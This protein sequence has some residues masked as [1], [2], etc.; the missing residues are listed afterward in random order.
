MR[1]LLFAAALCAA[2]VKAGKFERQALGVEAVRNLNDR[3]IDIL[4][5]AQRYRSLVADQNGQE[6]HN[7]DS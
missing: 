6:R 5:V 7:L 1:P 4:R 2:A 3:C